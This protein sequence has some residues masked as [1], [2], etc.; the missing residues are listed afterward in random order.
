MPEDTQ[1]VLSETRDGVYAYVSVTRNA[2]V[3]KPALDIK[4]NVWKK[5]LE[6]G[7]LSRKLV[8]IIILIVRC[9][10][11]LPYFLRI[12]YIMDCNRRMHSHGM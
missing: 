1:V 4:R 9:I 5:N 12:T 10:K 6:K 11:M 7:I 8:L 3:E 2:H